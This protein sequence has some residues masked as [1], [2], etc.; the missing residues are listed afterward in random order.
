MSINNSYKLFSESRLKK[1]VDKSNFPVIVAE[2]LQSPDNMGAVLRLASNIGA[3]KVWF[4][5]ENK[6]NFRHYKIKRR[7]S[8]AIDKIGWDYAG[9][10]EIFDFIPGGYH[11][12]AVETT[13]DAKNIFLENLP[14]KIALF[15]GNERYGL[16]AKLLKNIN[17]RVYIPMAG[18][19]SSMN[20]SHALSVALFEWLRQHH[21]QT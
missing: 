20:V 12:V 14:E 21:Y 18:T 17:K 8:G 4:V 9:Y 19:V 2:A 13:P 7:S 11:Y 15:V 10:D 16:S 1:D 5:Y 6:P 3:R